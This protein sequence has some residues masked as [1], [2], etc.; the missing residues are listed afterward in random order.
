LLTS[1]SILLEVVYAFIKASAIRK[2]QYEALKQR[3]GS[4]SAKVIF[5]RQMLKVIYHILKEKRVYISDE[6]LIQSVAAT[7]LYRV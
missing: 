1:G 2:K 3:K 4:N 6:Q 7:A 5:A